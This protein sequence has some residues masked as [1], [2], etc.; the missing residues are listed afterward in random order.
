MSSVQPVIVAEKF[1]AAPSDE[2]MGR[3]RSRSAA[4]I[5]GSLLPAFVLR[6]RFSARLPALGEVLGLSEEEELE[7]ELV[8]MRVWRAR[9]KANTHGD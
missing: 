7:E 1:P 6:C 8:A 9:A 4:R 5:C 2:S 3:L